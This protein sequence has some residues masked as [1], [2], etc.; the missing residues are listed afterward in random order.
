MKKSSDPDPELKNVEFSTLVGEIVHDTGHLLGQQFELL[1]AELFEETRRAGGAVASMAAGGGLLAAGG[2]LSGMMLA[3]LLQ[4]T[5]R[6]PLW[7]CYG[8]VGGGLGATGWGLLQQGRK[9][10]AQVQL[11]PPPETAAALKENVAWAKEQIGLDE[12]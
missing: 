1:R 4:R 3:H 8:A 11:V 2:L 7:L 6:M 12:H 10:I 5:T 9:S